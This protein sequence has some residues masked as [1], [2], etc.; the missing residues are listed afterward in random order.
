MCVWFHKFLDVFWGLIGYFRWYTSWK[1]CVSQEASEVTRPGPIDNHDIID[2]ESDA[3]DPQLLKNLE[4]AVDYV[5]VP[6]Q[7]WK[8]L[9]EWW[10]IVSSVLHK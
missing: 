7:V 8:K 2:S 1:R 9:V 5:L 10:L 6:E 4:E 3:S